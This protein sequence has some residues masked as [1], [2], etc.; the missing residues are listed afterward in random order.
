LVF[1]STIINRQSTI[2]P[3]RGFRSGTSYA[4]LYSL[5]PFFNFAVAFFKRRGSVYY[6]T[7]SAVCF[8]VKQFTYAVKAFSPHLTQQ[9]HCD[10][11]Q[12]ITQYHAP[13]YSIMNGR[14]MVG[15]ITFY[16]LWVNSRLDPILYWISRTRSLWIEPLLSAAPNGAKLLITSRLSI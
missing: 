7:Y 11:S 2:V 4:I 6:A 16:R 13:G 15:D 8:N 14:D 5:Y 3:E 10:I 1:K 12:F 9:I